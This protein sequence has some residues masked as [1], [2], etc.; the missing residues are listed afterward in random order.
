M[1]ALTLSLLF[2]FCSAGLVSCAQ[3]D[4][5]EVVSSVNEETLDE[6]Y[7][8][9]D[10]V[11]VSSFDTTPD[12]APPPEPKAVVD[13]NLLTRWS[14]GYND[15][16]WISFDFGMPKVISKIVIYWEAAYA[17][18]YDILISN[19]NDNWETLL[20]LKE[21]DGGSDELQFSQVKTRYVKLIG[22]RRFNPTWGISL[23][24]FLCFGPGNENIIDKPLSLVYPELIDKLEPKA[25]KADLP[26]I[27]KPLVSP[28]ALSLDELQKG[29]V[30]T[31][32]GKTELGEEASDETLKYLKE[33]G[34]RHLSIMI[35]W[36]QET[37]KENVILPDPKDT[38]NDQA[39]IH[40]INNAHGLGMKVMLKPHV[41]VKGGQWRGDIIPSKEWFDSY[42]DY[43]IYYALLAGQY[44]VESICIGTELVNTTSSEW[45]G[46]WRDIIREVRKIYPGRLVYGAN[47]NEYKTVGFWDDLDFIGI[48]AYFPLTI[49]KDPAK[50]ELI[51]AW[52][53]NCENIEKWL[54]SKGLHKPV[55]FTEVGYSS[56]DGTNTKPW[57]VFSNISEEF[58]DQEEQADSLEAM[59]TVCPGY[60]WFK[61]FYWWNFFPQERWSPLGYTIRGKIAEEVFSEWLERL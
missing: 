5:N 26:E 33:L 18:D 11:D 31:S 48:S 60:P 6:V 22:K 32:W 29:V 46:Y 23:W 36:T 10:S 17:V 19:D 56:A 58:V 25:V 53:E 30:Y 47:W 59:L 39:L 15:G 12:W 51:T 3:E 61:G 9:I 24:E 2:L 43:L 37:I 41:D 52:R 55:V 35:I 42:R 8:M 7:L 4:T 27:E 45:E 13:G 14:S 20:S 1:K 40:A 21:Q 57:S 28:G 49:K 16:Q 50:E 54:S 38:P 44:N 34:V